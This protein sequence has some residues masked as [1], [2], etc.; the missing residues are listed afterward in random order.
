VVFLSI[1]RCDRKV[2]EPETVILP[3]PTL[4]SPTD[5]AIINTNTPVLQ[6]N[7]VTNAI[8]YEV[9]VDNSRDFSSPE[10]NSINIFATRCTTN[11]LISDN[12]YWKVRAVNANEVNG[13]WSTVW[14]FTSEL[15][16]KGLH[17][18]IF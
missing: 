18:Q 7:A 16:M 2:T 4:S 14:S 10:Y 8:R 5:G 3:A 11:F 17:H 15:V 9:K 6:W 1:I 13:N 12:Y